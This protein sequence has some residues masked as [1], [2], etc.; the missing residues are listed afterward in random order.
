MKL[1]KDIDPIIHQ[2]CTTDSNCYLRLA[3]QHETNTCVFDTYL[4]LAVHARGRHCTT[5]S[6]PDMPAAIFLKPES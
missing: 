2:I 1:L 3:S 4:L 6:G 5:L